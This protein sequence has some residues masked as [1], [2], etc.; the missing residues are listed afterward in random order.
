MQ[1]SAFLPNKK[2]ERTKS[3]EALQTMITPPE[4]LQERRS[5]FTKAKFLLSNITIEPTLVFYILPSTMII[6][7]VQ[8]LNMEK[9]CRV[10]LKIPVEN[11]D[12]LTNG[13]ESSYPGYKLDEERVQTLATNMSIMKNV[14][15]IN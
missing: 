8:N 2:M 1:K 15:S 13:N 7:A 3:M 5:F 14:V 12:A 6:L 9:A 4:V 11:C 10:N